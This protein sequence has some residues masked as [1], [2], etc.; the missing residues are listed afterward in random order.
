MSE[1][2]KKLYYRRGGTLYANKL[3][4]SLF[5]INCGDGKYIV[6]KN[7]GYA[8]LVPINDPRA[9]YI[10]AR[11]GS[12]VLAVAAY[13]DNLLYQEDLNEHYASDTWVTLPGSLPFYV[14]ATMNVNFN[15]DIWQ[16]QDDGP[17]TIGARVI[18][19]DAV[20]VCEFTAGAGWNSGSGGDYTV[21][22]GIWS[23][24]FY[25]NR[26]YHNG[27]GG[28][29]ANGSNP[30]NKTGTLN[31]GP[32]THTAKVQVLASGWSRARSTK[33]RTISLS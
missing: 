25:Q 6:A 8:K 20:A 14:P 2:A 17:S 11:R 4:S 33:W 24:R 28:C 13:Y 16:Y 29:G 15:L 19:D 31:I 1:I 18:V 10:R 7:I 5:D 9:S 3:Y 27:S 22:D 12:E 26:L 32:G 21:T 30:G 23:D